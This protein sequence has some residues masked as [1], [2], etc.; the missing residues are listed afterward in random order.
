MA[1]HRSSPQQAALLHDRGHRK[2]WEAGRG[3]IAH[4]VHLTSNGDDDNCEADGE[5][6]DDAELEDAVPERVAP[7]F[8]TYQSAKDKYKDHV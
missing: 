3:R 6:H 5:A 8:A 7:A 1:L 2:P 4:T